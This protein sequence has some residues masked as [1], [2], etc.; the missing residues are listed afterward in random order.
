[1]KK[2]SYVCPFIA[3]TEKRLKMGKK[4]RKKDKKVLALHVNF[5]YTELV[6]KREDVRGC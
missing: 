6:V 2:F 1:M 4:R 3:K 5:M